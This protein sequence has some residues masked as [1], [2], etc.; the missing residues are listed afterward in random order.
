MKISLNLFAG[1][2]DRGGR[3]KS[4]L[5]LRSGRPGP[6][7]GC[8]RSALPLQEAHPR[9]EVRNTH[10]PGPP[11]SDGLCTDRI[12]EDCSI[13]LFHHLLHPDLRYVSMHLS[14]HGKVSACRSPS[15]DT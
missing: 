2:G 14:T 6:E 7:S 13:L 10:W 4:Y 11:R 12:R 8:Q 5:L 15:A 9:A 1:G 3:A